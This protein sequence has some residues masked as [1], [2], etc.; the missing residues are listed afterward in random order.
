MNEDVEYEY[1]E[2]EDDRPE[3]PEN[4][5]QHYDGQWVAMRGAVVVA[6]DPD[7]E[8]LRAHP[9]VQETDAIFPVGDPP[10]GFYMINV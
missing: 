7:E 6:A 8:A 2:E 4:D 1:A 5:L 10:S 3:L 9:D